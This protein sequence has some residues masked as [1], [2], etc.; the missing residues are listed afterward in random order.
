VFVTVSASDEQCRKAIGDF[1]KNCKSANPFNQRDDRPVLV[2]KKIWPFLCVLHVISLDLHT[3][4]S[5]TEAHIK[6]LL[7][8]KSTATNPLAGAA[9]TWNALLVLVSAAAAEARALRRSDLPPE[10]L[11][12]YDP[13]PHRN[14]WPA[15]SP[16]DS[17]NDLGRR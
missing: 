17:M 14:R 15:G 8:L 2:A 1:W 13:A 11:A 6:T 5:Q 10:L 12:D 3:S 7:A 9:T 16:D 4:T